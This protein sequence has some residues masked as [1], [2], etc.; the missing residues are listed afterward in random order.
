[1]SEKKLF[2][3]LGVSIIALFLGIGCLDTSSG[4][5]NKQNILNNM[6]NEYNLSLELKE[7]TSK[8]YSYS[9][10]DLN[11]TYY[12]KENTSVFFQQDQFITDVK[13][14]VNINSTKD[15]FVL[16]DISCTFISDP[17]YSIVSIINFSRLKYIFCGEKEYCLDGSD[18]E[19][20]R[21]GY[22]TIGNITIDYK[23]IAL[24]EIIKTESIY[25]NQVLI[26]IK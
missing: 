6:S 17:N 22:N 13:L 12:T 7:V 15:C 14:S 9:L 11:C 26:K 21:I 3:L 24:D 23:I 2:A 10:F 1:M 16:F 5:L 20:Y 8:C 4:N 19:Q 25:Y 18:N